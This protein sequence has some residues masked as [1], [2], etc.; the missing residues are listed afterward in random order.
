M[1]NSVRSKTAV[2]FAA[3]HFAFPAATLAQTAYKHRDANGQWVFSDQ[4]GDSVARGDSFSLP[5]ASGSPRISIDQTVGATATQLVA[6]NDCLC[7][8]TFQIKIEQSNLAGM[9]VSYTHLTL[10]TIYSV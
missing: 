10:P 1:S 8:V 7:V 6:I 3:L 5:H 4:A 2:A 9:A